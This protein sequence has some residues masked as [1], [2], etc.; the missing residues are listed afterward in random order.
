MSGTILRAWVQRGYG[1]PAKVLRLESF[2]VP[3]PAPDE[4]LVRIEASAIHIADVR[5]VQGAEGFRRPLPRTPGY[6]GVGRVAAVGAEVDGLRVGDRVFPPIGA[7]T[8]AEGLLARASDCVPAP[9]GDAAQLA[10]LSINPPT[11]RFLLEDFVALEPG[12]WVIQNAAN[13]SVGRY[14][15][16]LARQRGLRT[17]NVV[18]RESLMSELEA[19]GGDLVLLDGADL[20]ARVNEATGG[21]A[22][23]LGID[24]VGGAATTRIAQCL[25][26]GGQVVNYGSMSR[27]PCQMPF[28]LM[29]WRD[30]RLCGFSTTRQFARRT[31]EQRRRVLHELAAQVAAGA[32]R[33]RIAAVYALEQLPT[34]LQHALETGEAR[35]GKLV[36]R[37]Q[38]R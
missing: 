19:L 15:I 33:T 10:L 3:A 22:L 38:P 17:L 34:A 13:S 30:V 36:L 1:D 5:T 2:A 37:P 23:R 7:G 8:F 14:L 29:L 12:E 35:E 9:E 32:L 20:A 24:A 21:A 28:E 25:A 16:E 27:E 18:R 26:E 4:V 31:P 6:E 11:A